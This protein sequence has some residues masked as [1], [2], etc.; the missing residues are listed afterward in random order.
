MEMLLYTRP[1]LAFLCDEFKKHYHLENIYFSPLRKKYH[2]NK[3][4]RICR[5]CGSAYNPPHTTFKSDAHIIPEFLGNKHLTNPFECDQCNN[6]FSEYENH[7]KNYLG[8]IPTVLGTKGKKNK[9]PTHPSRDNMA[10]AE[11]SS[12]LSIEEKH[13]EFINSANG[14][15]LHF[16]PTTGSLTIQ[17]ANQPYIPFL[18]YKALVKIGLSCISETDTSQYAEAFKMLN[19]KSLVPNGIMPFTF[20]TQT[21]IDVDRPRVY[22]FKKNSNGS[23]LP[24]HVVILQYGN[25]LFQYFLPLNKGDKYY[26]KSQQ[27]IFIH[28]H[29]P[30]FP[31]EV[32]DNVQI[33]VDIEQ[34]GSTEPNTTA[35]QKVEMQLD[36]SN[37]EFI[38][39]DLTTG[40]FTKVDKLPENPRS[41]VLVEKST[42]ITHKPPNP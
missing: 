23:S 9:R 27:P 31:I 20:V 34:L 37:Q 26:Q 12:K 15:A 39:F 22:L 28:W 3:A 16:N 2:G 8:I 30:L 25:L 14:K 32:N 17:A 40:E 38:K 41:V 33:W 29:P 10:K 13:L 36:I 6:K 19:N 1:N 11:F 35:R 4:L 18:A 5:F 7:L 24:S 42:R 21:S